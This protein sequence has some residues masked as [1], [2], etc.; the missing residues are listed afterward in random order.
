MR[1][2]MYK[3]VSQLIGEDTWTEIYPE[4]LEL[5]ASLVGFEKIEWRRF[6]GGPLRKVTMEEWKEVMPPLVTKIENEQTRKAF[7]DLIPK[8]YNRFEEQGGN[9]PPSYIMKMTK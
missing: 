9:Y 4:E 8:I 3:S 2:Q 1:W 7:L 5:A 6:E